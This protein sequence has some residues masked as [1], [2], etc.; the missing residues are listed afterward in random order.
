VDLIGRQVAGKVF[1]SGDGGLDHQHPVPGV[2]VAHATLAL[3]DRVHVMDV[4]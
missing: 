3:E 1:G 2:L 4:P